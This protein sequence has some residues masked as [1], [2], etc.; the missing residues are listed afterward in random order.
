M[1]KIEET[2]RISGQP[3]KLWLTILLVAL[4]AVSLVAGSVIYYCRNQSQNASI[5]TK[6]ADRYLALVYNSE[7]GLLPETL[8]NKTYWITSDNLLAFY[9]L[10]NF[11]PPVSASIESKI[12]SYASAQGL[13][14]DSEGLPISYKHEAVI[15]DVLSL[16][17]RS[18]NTK[19]ILNNSGYNIQAEIDNDNLMLD[20]QNYS[21]L[22]AYKGLSYYNMG[23]PRNA[24]DQ[25]NQMMQKWDGH[26]FQD[27]AFNKTTGLYDTYKLAL[28]L[29]LAKDLK[30]SP[31]NQTRQM[32]AI[33]TAMQDPISGGI[34]TRYTYTTVPQIGGSINTETTSL[35]A[36]ACG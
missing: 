32:T 13:P 26:G 4:I 8:D 15:G 31:T 35:V 3:M 17:F 6:N 11:D 29:L 12:K 10:K 2:A 36:I 33:I 23:L 25:Y 20:W 30:I 14:T 7:L 24:T 22:I 19:T 1:L 27:A 28:A 9:A 16:P 5:I 34:H 21:D 18:N